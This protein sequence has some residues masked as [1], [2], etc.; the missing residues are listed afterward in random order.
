MDSKYLE[1]FHLEEG[2]ATILGIG[3]DLLPLR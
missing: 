2:E 1:I 3:A